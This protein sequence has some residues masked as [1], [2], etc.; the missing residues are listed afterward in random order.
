MGR[1]L[2]ARRRSDATVRFLAAPNLPGQMAVLVAVAL[3]VAQAVN[4]R[5]EP[6]RTGSRSGWSRR[7]GPVVARI[8][9]A[10]QGPRNKRG[11]QTAGRCPP[12]RRRVTKPPGIV[13][14]THPWASNP[15]AGRTSFGNP[16]SKRRWRAP[17][18]RKRASRSS[19]SSPG[20]AR[21]RS[22][23]SALCQDVARSAP[24][25]ITFARSE[26]LIAVEQ[27][28]VGWWATA[29]PLAGFRKWPFPLATDRPDAWC[30]TRSCCCLFLLATRRIAQPLRTLARRPRSATIRANPIAAIPGNRPARRAP[31]LIV[32]FN[33]L[34]TRVRRDARG[35]GSY[36][37]ARSGTICGTA[38]GGAP[39]PDR[40]GRG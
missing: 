35:K 27:P 32:A 28:K 2:H 4:F 7:W 22:Q 15:I 40:I 39:R 37:G 26:L 1:R 14:R 17:P 5:T 18:G 16:R 8:I 34:R 11:R 19:R 36:A 25:A 21:L 24:S 29:N 23:R 30:S 20:S 12:P 31:P 3:F 10:S 33:D 9:D 38:A 6:A 13:F